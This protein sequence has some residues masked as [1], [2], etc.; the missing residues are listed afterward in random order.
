MTTVPTLTVRPADPRS[1]EARAL[2]AQSHALLASLYPPE[3]NHYLSVDELAQPHIDFWIAQDDSQPF[4]CVALA[5]LHGYGEVK[6]M[7]VDPTARGQ[8]VGAALIRTLEDRARATGLAILR[9]ETGDNLDAAHRLYRRHG[10][11]ETGPFGDYEEGPHSVFLEKR[12]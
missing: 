10:F 2:L 7:F 5:R 4:G 9:L 8:G 12:L 11:T 3:H 1:E 6:S